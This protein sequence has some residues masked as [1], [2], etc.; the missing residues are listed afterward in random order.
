MAE[1]EP[2]VLL[3]EDDLPLRLMLGAALR[4][5]GFRVWAAADGQEALDLYGRYRDD[6]RVVLCD[7]RMPRLGG[8]EVLAALRRDAPDLPVCLMSGE[9]EEEFQTTGAAR[10]FWK[11]FRIAEVVAALFRL[12]EAPD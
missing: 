5:R 8:L 10:F 3:A 6:I 7:V 12:V 11:P 1:G 2:G 4:R 9:P